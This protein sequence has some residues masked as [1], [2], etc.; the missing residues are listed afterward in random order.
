MLPRG[1]Q[2]KLIGETTTGAGTTER[3]GSIATDSIL[4]SLWV[5][6]ISSGSLTVTV[7][8]ETVPGREEE[9]ITFPEISD[10]TSELV[11][12]KSGASLANFRVRASYTGVCTYEVYVRAIEGAGESS[13]R[14]IG[15]S[16]WENSQGDVTTTPALLIPSSLTDRQGLIIR[17]NSASGILYVSSSEDTCTTTEGWPLYPYEVFPVD[18]SSGAEVWARS[19]A[20]TIDA[21]IFQAGG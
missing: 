15:A 17:N 10:V 18:L 12:K 4:V 19:S 20:G 14:I 13:S 3:V 21:R 9:I 7:V 2:Q 5:S 1:T 6:S 16:T 8:N 11:I